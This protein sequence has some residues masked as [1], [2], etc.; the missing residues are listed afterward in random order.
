M[1]NKVTIPFVG[2]TAVDRTVNVNNQ[3]TVNFMQAVK[4]AGAKSPYV[5]ETA[6]GLVPRA[7]VGDGPIRTS[8]MVNSSIRGEGEELYG[9]FGTRLIA[10]TVSAGNI[11]IGT[12]EPGTNRVSIAR[13]RTHIML[14]DGERGYTYDGTT[15]AQITDLD[16]PGISDD[17]LP[18]QCVYIDGFFVVVDSATDNFFISEGREDPTNWNALDFGASAVAPDN[19][20]AVAATE[21][22]LW[23][24]GIESAQA[25]Y[26][27]GNPDFPYDIVLTATQEV[28]CLAPDSVAESDDGIFYLATT[29]EGGRY[30]YQI[31]GQSGRVVSQDEQ[32]AFLDTVT[33]PTDAY[34]FIYKQAGKSFY[35]L[36]LSGNTGPDGR[37]SSTLIYNIKAGAWETRELLDGTAWRIGG[38]GILGNTNIGGSRLQGQTFELSLT[39][40]TDAGQEMIRRRRTQV[41]HVN[42][43]LM[44]WWSIVLDL[45]TATTPLL[46]ADPEIKLR[47]SDDHGQTFSDWLFEPLGRIGET[48][49]RVVFWKLGISRNRIFEIE[50]SEDLPLT[51]V[52]AYAEVEVLGD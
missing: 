28:G 40:Y 47:Y 29:P 35:V 7:T 10:Q 37:T 20:L 16:F 3:A 41:Y 2:G 36:Q 15:F 38:H 19:A 46:T 14:V 44:D 6:P 1:R 24:F 25:F 39:S 34:G 48:M 5:L 49:H 13:G 51:V 26:N 43:M 17:G 23:I 8:R 42:N 22:L 50:C 9:V 4:G 45:S 27:S 21:S 31:Q 32:E 18:T 11:E 30:V 12:L 52:A 33:D